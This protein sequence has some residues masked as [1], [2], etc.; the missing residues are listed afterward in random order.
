MLDRIF[1]VLVPEIQDPWVSAPPSGL[2]LIPEFISDLEE[3]S[4]IGS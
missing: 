4:L 1:V 2:H 3:T